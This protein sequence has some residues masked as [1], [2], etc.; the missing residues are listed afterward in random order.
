MTTPKQDPKDAELTSIPSKP[1]PKSIDYKRSNKRAP[2]EMT[3][4]RK[5]SVIR[6]Q[7][8]GKRTTRDPRFDDLSGT[9]DDNVF[10]D[11]YGFIKD[12]RSEE[13]TKLQGELK[14][15]KDPRK[16]DQLIRLI[17]KMNTSEQANQIKTERQKL[18]VE[19]RKKA[20]GNVKD[21]KN[22]YFAKKS[23]LRKSEL[24]NKFEQLKKEGKVEKYLA[25]RRKHNLQKD[26]KSL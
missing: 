24:K 6:E 4:K 22:P 26:K 23:E 8:T 25:K 16:R 13:K 3:S 15:C 14:K 9:F 1:D 2:R 18:K 17:N 12:I 20:M 7:T 5:V 19:S 21:G 10:Q 11:S